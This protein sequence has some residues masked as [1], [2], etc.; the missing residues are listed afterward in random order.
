LPVAIGF[1]ISSPEQAARIAKFADA[2]VVGSALIQAL[3]KAKGN[4]EKPKRAGTF[5]AQMKRA[6][7]RV[8]KH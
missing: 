1:G 2:A 6:I 8:R 7:E 3:E 5:V 4:A